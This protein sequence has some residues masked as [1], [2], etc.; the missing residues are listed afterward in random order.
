M[1]A[2]GGDWRLAV[3]TPWRRRGIFDVLHAAPSDVNCSAMKMNDPLAL[4]W[5][6]LRPT[7]RSVE[8]LDCYT[9]SS[10]ERDDLCRDFVTLDP[11]I[12]YRSIERNNNTTKTVPFVFSILKASPAYYRYPTTLLTQTQCG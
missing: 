8:Q 2:G 9:A 3:Q 5:K 10:A 4:R 12:A 11:L 7:F 6:R 1:A